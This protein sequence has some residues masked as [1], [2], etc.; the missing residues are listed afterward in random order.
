[1]ADAR[2]AHFRGELAADQLLDL[3]E[4]DVLVVGAD[5]GLGRRSE[6]HLWQFVGLPEAFRQGY[7]ADRPGLLVVLPA[8]SDEVAAHHGFDRQ[9]L[10]LA[11]H[12]GAPFHLS[13]FLTALD[14]G[15]RS[16]AIEM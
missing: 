13:R 15:V 11:G 2:V 9:G 5:L 16:G 1:Q 3:C 8:R 4:R 7:P 14:Y 10:E 12:H 6:D